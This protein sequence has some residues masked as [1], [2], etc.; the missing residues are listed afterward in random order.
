MKSRQIARY[1]VN[2]RDAEQTPALL[3]KGNAESSWSTATLRQPQVPFLENQLLTLTGGI[4]NPQA[5]T[6][7][8]RTL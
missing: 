7:R 3:D 8:N 4:G 1:E 2:R 6:V 5:H